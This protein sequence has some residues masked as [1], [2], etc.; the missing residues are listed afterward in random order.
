MKKWDKTYP[1]EKIRDA[2]A[3]FLL[4][5]GNIP[6]APGWQRLFTAAEQIQEQIAGEVYKSRSKDFLDPFRTVNFR[7]E[8]E[9]TAVLGTID[10]N[11]FVRQIRKESDV[12]IR[13]FR[14]VR[15]LLK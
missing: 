11:E 8:A 5:E 12:M 6:D 14:S 3:C 9:K 15:Q 4:L 10:G 7:N 13:R 2:W 1:A